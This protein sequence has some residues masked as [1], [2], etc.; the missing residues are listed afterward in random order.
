MHYRRSFVLWLGAFAFCAAQFAAA[1]S[2]AGTFH[3]TLPNGLT[4]IVV[5]DRSLPVVTVGWATREITT[6]TDTANNIGLLNALLFTAANEA[7]PSGAMVKQRLLDTGTRY[8]LE[9]GDVHAL[10]TFQTMLANFDSLLWL[11]ANAATAPLVFEQ[12]IAAAKRKADSM[13]RAYKTGVAWQVTE[14]RNRILRRNSQPAFD[15][16][17]D[18]QAIQ[19]A[20]REQILAHRAVYTNPRNAV[21]IVHGPVNRFDAFNKAQQ[22]FGEWSAYGMEQRAATVANRLPYAT[23]S[24]VATPLSHVPTLDFFYNGPSQPSFDDAVT[25]LV[26][27]ELIGGRNGTVTRNLQGS[28][29]VLD[30][31]NRVSFSG[32]ALLLNFSF[33]VAPDKFESAY[34]ALNDQLDSLAGGAFVNEALLKDAKRNAL[35]TLQL[36]AE[37]RQAQLQTIAGWWAMGLHENAPAYRTAVE[38]VTSERV[39]DFMRRYLQSRPSVRVLV[40]SPAVQAAYKTDRVFTAFED[41]NNVTVAFERNGDA[42]VG[43]ANQLNAVVQ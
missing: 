39:R 2:T 33:A 12:D 6:G 40:V 42:I 19:R 23:H 11:V 28:D 29:M 5:E 1:Q 43:D 26:V 31:T 8:R 13:H 20:T 17:G 38:G 15:P 9:L 25:A 24:V 16:M 3:R 21:L 10:H 30:A 4:V 22:C 41:V 18:H 14:R 36:R 34:P 37:D 7:M 35:Q 27:Q 32:N